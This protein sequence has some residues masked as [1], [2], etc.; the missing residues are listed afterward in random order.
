M[1]ACPKYITNLPF[2]MLNA[3]C[4]Y[5]I[6]DA[7][8][9]KVGRVRTEVSGRPSTSTLILAYRQNVAR[10]PSSVRRS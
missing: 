9:C 7:Y 10:E 4:T 6:A 1:N 5:L 8:V 2:C 3:T